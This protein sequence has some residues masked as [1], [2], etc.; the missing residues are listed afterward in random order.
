MVRVTACNYERPPT[1]SPNLEAPAQ[2]AAPRAISKWCAGI[3]V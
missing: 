2:A 1:G 3:A